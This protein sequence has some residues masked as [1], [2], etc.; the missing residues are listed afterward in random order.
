LVGQSSCWRLLKCT[1]IRMVTGSPDG[2]PSP[3]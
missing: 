1:H 3:A 2:W